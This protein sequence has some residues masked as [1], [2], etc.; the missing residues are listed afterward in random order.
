MGREIRRVIPNWN[1]PREDRGG[2]HPLFDQCF[3]EAYSQYFIDYNNFKKNDFKEA[4]KKYGYDI[5]DPRKAFN[6]WHGASP[7][8]DYY[9]PE[10]TESES[11]WWQV[12]ETVSEGTPVTPPFETQDELI[13]YLVENGDYWDQARREKGSNSGMNCSPWPREQAENFVKGPGWAPS[14]IISTDGMKIGVEAL[15]KAKN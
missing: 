10:W 1:H 12:Y 11:T 8:V 9:R 4:A 6:D 5:S 14:M 7:D 13:D 15:Y 2:Y 3:S